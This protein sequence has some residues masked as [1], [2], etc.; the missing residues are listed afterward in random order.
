MISQ[1]VNHL[2][3]E[4]VYNFILEFLLMTF[5]GISR[6]FLIICI[7]HAKLILLC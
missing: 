6:L 1:L 2:I 3:K 4:S 7:I 5:S